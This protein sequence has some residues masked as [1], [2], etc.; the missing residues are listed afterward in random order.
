MSGNRLV[1]GVDDSP[2]EAA[3]KRREAAREVAR[4]QCDRE[5]VAEVERDAA[6]EPVRIVFR[7]N[8]HHRGARAGD[9][10]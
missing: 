10:R 1:F 2:R 7:R 4:L 8:H 5:F 9:D 3:R 6:G